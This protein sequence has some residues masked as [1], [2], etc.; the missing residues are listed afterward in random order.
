M[1]N[2]IRKV[3]FLTISGLAISG[4]SIPISTAG[5][6]IGA[7]LLIIAFLLTPKRLPQIAKL[8]LQ[9]FAIAGLLLGIILAIG[10]LWSS[11]TPAVAWG[12]FLKM[13]AYYLIPV[14]LVLINTGKMRNYVLFSFAAV[15][16]LSVILSCISAWLNYPLFMA[17]PGDWYIFRTHTYHN[18]FAALMGAAVL[19][20]LITKKLPPLS[21]STL[22]FIF[23]LISY[24]ILF[25]VAGRTGQIVYLLMVFFILSLW[26]WRIGIVLSLIIF[27]ALANVLPKYSSAVNQG[28]K[29]TESNLSA[30]AKGDSNTSVGLRLE[31]QKNSI[32][33]IQEKPFFGHGTGSFKGEYQRILGSGDKA[34]SSQNPHNDYLWLG[35]ELGVFGALS[36][37]GLLIAAAWQGRHLQAAWKWTLYS[38]LLGMGVSTTANSFF[39]DNI[40]GSAFV[41]L[42]CALLSGPM[43][44]VKIS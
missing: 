30:Y 27:T 17:I 23:V 24:D 15:V 18:F 44:K 34:L 7:A 39:T 26:N 31:W 33:L 4:A 29:N 36:L 19:S 20:T 12:F 35:V 38:L 25:L 11:A 5:Q 43:Q 9:P 22:I 10:T 6:N 1:N 32:K 40:T 2:V 3:D 13:R 21:R 42:A 41:M 8:C 37:L 16:S 14:F 28:V